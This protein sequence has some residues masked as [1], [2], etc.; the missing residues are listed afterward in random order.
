MQEDQ[1]EI[2]RP[3]AR[4]K[5]TNIS[6]EDESSH[7]AL[8]S[9]VQGSGANGHHYS[10][11]LKNKN[12]SEEFLSKASQVKVTLPIEEFLSRFFGLYSTQAEI[13]ARA[14]GYKTVQMD[15]AELQMQEDALDMQEE[16]IAPEMP[17]DT[18][19]K[20]YEDYILSQLQSFEIMKS[21]QDSKEMLENLMQ[22]DED[23]YLGMLEDQALIEKAFRKIARAEKA[24]AKQSK[25][26]KESKVVA[27]KAAVDD[28]SPNAC[29]VKEEVEA[30]VVK[31]NKENPMSDIQKE[32]VQIQVEMVEKSTLE[33]VLKA[34]DEA[35]VELQ[36][37]RDLLAQFEAEKKEAI[38]KARKQQ[39][40]EAVKD[41]AKTEVLFKAVKEAAEEDFQAVV[42][43]LAEMQAVVEKSA[44]FE[45]QGAS[46][47][48]EALVQ[49]SAVEK[50]IKS[51][52]LNK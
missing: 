49:E 9:K 6:F 43:A 26:Q 39:M 7:I 13:L 25:E 45:E 19:G 37:A 31:S 10:M 36:K 41:E 18:E 35:L 42:K 47:Q 23:E 12:F 38:A 30:S 44:L 27:S 17:E 14:M 22:L 34:K 16:Q 50:L 28:T 48:E 11:L 8:V 52:L 15:K 32:E 51:K 40:L 2:K 5:L 4:R 21:M 33:A 20:E 29:E 3:K 1:Q 46:I 24:L